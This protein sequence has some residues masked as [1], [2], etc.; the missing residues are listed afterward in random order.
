MS[1][2]TVTTIDLLRHGQTV[3][4]DILRGRIDVPLSEQGY[5]QMSERVSTYLDAGFPWQRL[6]TSPLQRCASFA[7][8]L[9]QEHGALVS[10]NEGFLEMDF[11]AWDGRSFDE[12]RK[13]DPVLFSRI[14]RE[15][16]KYSPPGGESFP[17]FMTRI[18]GAWEQLLSAH[19]GE[20]VLL[21]CHGGVIR[22][23]LASI[24]QT[25]LTSLGRIEVPYACMSRIRIHHQADTEHWP[26]LVFHNPH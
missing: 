1:D 17:E 26:Q 2:I 22:A 8:D 23:L 25:P 20:H 4:D 16:H 11:G 7:N 14:W 5:R 3:A 19:Q 10:V 12:L 18:T 6:V 15:P 13:E 9:A 21:V 24:M